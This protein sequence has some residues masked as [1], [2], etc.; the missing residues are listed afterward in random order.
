MAGRLYP[1]SVIAPGSSGINKQQAASILDPKWATDA[2]NTVIDENGRLASR[3][4]WTAV[5]S[6]AL[7]GTPS[8]SQIYEYVDNTGAS[9]IISAA[10]NKLYSGTT[11]L[12]DITGS[13]TIIA[14]N[15]KF[16]NFNGKLIGWQSGHTPIVWTGSG[17]FAHITAGAGSLPNG[18]TCLAAFGRVW[19]VK[20]DTDNTV[21]QYSDLLD[22][23]TWSGGSSGSIDLKTVWPSGQDSIV[24]LAEFNNYL[25]IF[26]KRNIIV[27]SGADD[28]STMQLSDLIAGVGCISRDTV[29]DLSTDIVFLSESGV[30][31]FSRT[32]DQPTMPL[33][34]LSKNVRDYLL[35]FRVLEN[36]ANIKGVYHEP[37]GFYVLSFP[38]SGYEFVFDIRFPN[39]DGSSRV[40]MWRDMEPKAFCS[41]RDR[42]LY[43]G[44]PGVIGKYYGYTD[45]A[46]T[47]DIVYRS[48]WTDFG[49]QIS[50]NY[51]IPKKAYTTFIG[52][53]GLTINYKWAYD[54]VE[55][56]Q[57]GSSTLPVDPYVAEWGV[58]E[59]GIGQWSDGQ[60]YVTDNT[61]PFGF[62]RVVK[63]GFNTTIN[64]AKLSLQQI[65]VLSKLG[66]M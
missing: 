27:Y 24:A 20:S 10:D 11:T 32:V 62:G 22:E 28:P 59:W 53:H 16:Q 40:T 18:S 61:D 14:N 26:G 5:T 23:T 13:C 34:D 36:T 25:V 52:G 41:A 31:L 29:A 64:G 37:E 21:L 15:W 39:E 38:V 30:R 49:E 63:F 35:A 7:A 51:K 55:S 60:T 6:S 1:L 66:R 44:K 57:T 17:N 46:A 3:K 56:Y 54:Y 2:I 58:S 47:Y 9:T 12:T 33:G 4:G 50:S 45:N 65:N 19:A 42:T 8:I 43:I 48:T